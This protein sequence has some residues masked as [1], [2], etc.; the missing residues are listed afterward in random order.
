MIFFLYTAK[1]SFQQKIYFDK[2]FW[3]VSKRKLEIIYS[4]FVLELLSGNFNTIKI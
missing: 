4:K 1:D 3:L 2:V